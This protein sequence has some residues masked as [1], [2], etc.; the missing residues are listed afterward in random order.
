[1]RVSGDIVRVGACPPKRHHLHHCRPPRVHDFIQR[2]R[3]GARASCVVGDGPERVRGPDR[4]H[5]LA[6]HHR[7]G[8]LRAVAAIPRWRIATQTSRAYKCH[9]NADFDVLGADVAYNV[10]GTCVCRHFDVRLEHAEALCR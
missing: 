5:H 10:F 6:L 4:G 2:D 8:P 7:R 9:L 1:M 3:H